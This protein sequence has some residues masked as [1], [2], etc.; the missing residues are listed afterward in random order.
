MKNG[1]V[2]LLFPSILFLYHIDYGFV[3]V[4]RRSQ[5]TEYR[6]LLLE[7]IAVTLTV[8]D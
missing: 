6:L 4:V 8:E 5:D 3:L 7:V 2:K 1:F